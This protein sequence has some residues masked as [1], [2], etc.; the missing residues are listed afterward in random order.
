MNKKQ[1]IEKGKASGLAY[2]EDAELAIVAG[3]RGDVRELYFSY[4]YKAMKEIVRR[5][6]VVEMP[7]ITSSACSYAHLSFLEGLPHEEFW[8]LYC[9]RKN[10]IIKKVQIS[11]GDVSGTVVDIKGILKGA[12][13]LNA[14]AIVLCHNHPSGNVRP[15]NEDISTTKKI[16]E[17]CKLMNTEVLDHIIIGNGLWYSFRDEGML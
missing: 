17:L 12:I 11:K 7:Q 8:V 3:F 5:H 1:L 2:L 6:V 9:N 13:E 15:S 16:S 14:S 10:N 4:E